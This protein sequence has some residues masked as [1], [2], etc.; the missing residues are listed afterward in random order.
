MRVKSFRTWMEK[1]AFQWNLKIRKKSRMDQRKSESRRKAKKEIDAQPLEKALKPMEI[2]SSILI[3][4]WILFCFTFFSN[5]IYIIRILTKITNFF[6]VIL[7]SLWA[8]FEQNT[9]ILTASN[10]KKQITKA[11]TIWHLTNINVVFFFSSRFSSPFVCLF[12]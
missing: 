3:N 9:K 2:Q 11:P 1:M 12:A 10:K 8:S 6:D 5:L 7:I 4:C